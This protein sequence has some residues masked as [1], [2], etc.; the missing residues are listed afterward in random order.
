M[1]RSSHSVVVISINGFYHGRLLHHDSMNDRE[2]SLAIYG[3][4]KGSDVFVKIFYL[5]LY[6]Q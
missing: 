4:G 6:Y 3:Q 2:L 5:E 1:V